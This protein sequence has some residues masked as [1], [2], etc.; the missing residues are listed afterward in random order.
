ML[1]SLLERGSFGSS[2]TSVLDPY[3]RSGRLKSSDQHLLPTQSSP[4]LRW[5]PGRSKRPSILVLLPWLPPVPLWVGL[6]KTCLGSSLL[7]LYVRAHEVLGHLGHS[8]L[9]LEE[10][11]LNNGVGQDRGMGREM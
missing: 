4:G 7:H 5:A 6:C 10:E 2:S 8:L 11:G 3:C 1:T 9:S